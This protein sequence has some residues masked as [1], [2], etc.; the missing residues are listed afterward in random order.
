MPTSRRRLRRFVILFLGRSGGT[1]LASSLAEH[2]MIS[3]K[4]EPLGMLARQGADHQVDWIRAFLRGPVIGRA[5]AVGFSTKIADIARPDSF[6][7]ELRAVG[8]SVIWLDRA[9]EVKQTV[10]V[11]RARQLN[12]AIG[13]WNRRP[14]DH[15]LGETAVDPDDFATRLVQVHERRRATREYAESL[16]L[17]LLRLDYRDLLL[18]PEAVFRQ[19]HAHIGVRPL[20]VIGSTYKVT[21]DDLRESVSNFDELRAPYVGTEYEAMFDEVLS[22]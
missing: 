5:G 13:H 8:A 19:A 7:D 2:P 16:G 4:T 21:S 9:N 6:A 22:V 15:H 17:A 3:V 14:P 1:Y 11:I 18:D 12:E 10:S 20:P